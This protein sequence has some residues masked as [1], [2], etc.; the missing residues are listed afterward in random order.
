[1][2]MQAANA[3]MQAVN[4][5]MQPINGKL[6]KNALHSASMLYDGTYCIEG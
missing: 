4:A 5:F 1:M 3:F 2:F 6:S